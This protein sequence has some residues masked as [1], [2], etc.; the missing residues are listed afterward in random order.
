[1]LK[2]FGKRVMGSFIM[3]EVR[4]PYL[5]LQIILSVSKSK[6]DKNK[7]PHNLVQ[8]QVPHMKGSCL[9]KK[10]NCTQFKS[11]CQYIGNTE[12]RGRKQHQEKKKSAK[13]RKWEILQDKW[14]NFSNK[15]GHEKRWWCNKEG[16]YRLKEIYG[17]QQAN[18]VCRPCWKSDSTKSC[19]E[20]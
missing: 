17:S 1:M 9:K 6:A 3:D 18:A 14:H 19:I 7:I 4:W 5:N 10:K 12:N 2:P 15:S 8:Y 11:N 20:R 13:P 16:C